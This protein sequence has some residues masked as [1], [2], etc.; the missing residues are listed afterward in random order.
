MIVIKSERAKGL[1]QIPQ[2]FD[3][4]NLSQMRK[5]PS[6]DFILW[7]N[8]ER[9]G[10][11]VKKLSFSG[12]LLDHEKVLLEAVAG[13]MKGRSLAILDNLSLRECEAFLRDR[14]SELA[15]ENIESSDESKF[16]KFFQ[17]LRVFRASEAPSEYEFSPKNG[18]FREMRLVDKIRELKAFLNSFE[19][20]K[21]Y[22]GSIG[23]ELIDVQDLTVYVQAPYHSEKDRELFEELHI[24]GVSTFSEESLNFIPEA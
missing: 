6:D 13:L 9:D 19:V 2:A 23:P 16:K 17:W 15:L 7:V 12:N 22:Q 8:L 1:L 24:L 10:Q 3:Q 5:Y 14:N 18:G 20:Q 11:N 4:A 21:L